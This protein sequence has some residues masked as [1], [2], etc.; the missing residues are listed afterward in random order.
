MKF[1]LSQ[2]EAKRLALNNQGLHK[3][4]PFGVGKTAT[5]RCIEQLGYVQIDTISVVNRAHHHT[6]WSRLPAYAQHQLDTLQAERRIFEYWYHAAAYLPIQ[7][8]RFCLRRMHAIASGE[9]HWFQPEK[10]VMQFALDR[11]KAEGPL[12]AKDFAPAKEKKAGAWWEWKP[13]K[14]ALEQLFMEGKLMITR[15]NNF[16]KV[17]DLPEN[18]LPSGVDTSV[19]NEEEFCRFLIFRAIRAH[20]VVTDSEICYLRKGIKKA[21]QSELQQLL[22]DGEVVEVCVGKSNLVFYSTPATLNALNKTRREKR[23]HLLTPFDNAV[24]QRKRL[25]QL[26]DFDYQIECYVP[27]AKRVYGYFCLPILYGDQFVGRLD[28]KADRKTGRFLVRNLYLEKSLRN[29]DAFALALKSQLVKLAEFNG[30]PEIT[31]ERTEPQGLAELI[32]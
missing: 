11:I 23:V 22:S 6:L 8:F 13:A 9:L 7:D 24:I 17:Y 20:A 31:I 10:K 4:K 18:V 15:R 16:H 2:R 21:V 3:S 28:P 30:C 5:L 29:V 12:M 14:Q 1:T 27:E 32:S 26:F 19:P 25:H